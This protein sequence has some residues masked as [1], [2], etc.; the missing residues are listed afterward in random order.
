MGDETFLHGID[1]RIHLFLVS[2]VHLEAALHLADERVRDA[3]HLRTVPLHPAQGVFCERGHDN[4]LHRDSGFVDGAENLLRELGRVV[5][6]VEPDT[7]A[8]ALRDFERLGK[9]NDCL[10]RVSA[11]REASALFANFGKCETGYLGVPI[12]YRLERAVVL[13]NHMT[14]LRFLKVEFKVVEFVLRRNPVCSL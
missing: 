9:R 11:L 8:H 10:V 5:L 6:E 4:A 2:R 12:H 7:L 13:K 14:V 3:A 1:R